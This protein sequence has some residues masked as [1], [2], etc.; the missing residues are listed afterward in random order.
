MF[1]ENSFAGIFCDEF[2]KKMIRA[3]LKVHVRNTMLKKYPQSNSFSDFFLR[4]G[5]AWTEFYFVGVYDI[6]FIFPN[7][8]LEHI[9][10]SLPSL[11]SRRFPGKF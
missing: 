6:T 5:L 11:S 7:F 8:C 9:Y 3:V 2:F 10:M 4:E 1:H